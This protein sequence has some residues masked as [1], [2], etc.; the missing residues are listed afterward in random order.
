MVCGKRLSGL[1]KIMKIKWNREAFR[2]VRQLPKVTHRLKRMGL[3]IAHDC[4]RGYGSRPHDNARTRGRVLVAH[5]TWRAVAD[6]RR[7]NTM[8]KALAQ[9]KGAL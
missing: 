1:L 6:N 3:Q 2:E 7:N 5:D 8:V 4:G 9:N